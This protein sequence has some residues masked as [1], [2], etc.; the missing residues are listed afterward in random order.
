MR[1]HGL[2]AQPV[3]LDLLGGQKWAYVLVRGPHI[4]PAVLDQVATPVLS[5][6]RRI[7]DRHVRHVSVSLLGKF[8]GSFLTSGHHDT[9]ASARYRGNH[10]EGHR[11]PTTEF[12][13]FTAAGPAL[14]SDRAVRNPR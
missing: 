10:P 4:H 12:S 2:G 1:V 9:P 6:A 13:R 3:G 8:H 5:G 11:G 14:T 7:P